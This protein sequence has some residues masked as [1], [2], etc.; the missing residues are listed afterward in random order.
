MSTLP[1]SAQCATVV[2][3][4]RGGESPLYV[5]ATA[6]PGDDRSARYTGS[7]RHRIRLAFHD[8]EDMVSRLHRVQAESHYHQDVLFFDVLPIRQR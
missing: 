7:K 5:R 1:S 3:L 4:F 6:R 8:A 2:A